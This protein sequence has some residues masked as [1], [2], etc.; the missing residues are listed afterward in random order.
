M[1]RFGGFRAN[2]GFVEPGLPSAGS[3]PAAADRT[4]EAGAGLGEAVMAAG[5]STGRMPGVDGG[6]AAVLS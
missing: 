4:G 2:P 6:N 5:W 1:L 3:W